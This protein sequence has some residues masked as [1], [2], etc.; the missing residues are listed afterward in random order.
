MQI[1]KRIRR[2]ITWAILATLPFIVKDSNEQQ[3]QQLHKEMENRRLIQE[4]DMSQ[5][6]L[7]TKKDRELQEKVEET[8]DRYTPKTDF[9]IPYLE[10]DVKTELHGLDAE[11]FTL[12]Y[13]LNSDLPIQFRLGLEAK[14]KTKYTGS[15]ALEEVNLGLSRDI[16]GANTK[17][18]IN[19]SQNSQPEYR[20][21]VNFNF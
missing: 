15:S 16:F 18:Q 17:Y 2:G 19:L 10:S 7:S 4:Y 6:K 12:K 3:T 21:S 8:M 9:N 20:F 13:R 1:S 5:L 14:T 11:G